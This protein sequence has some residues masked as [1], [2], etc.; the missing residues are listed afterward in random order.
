MRTNPSQATPRARRYGCAALARL[1]LN[2]QNR[3]MVAAAGGVKV[4]IVAM[5][6]HVASAAVQEYGW[7][8]LAC[9]HACSHTRAHAHARTPRYGCLAL[10]RLAF[11]EDNRVEV[12]ECARREPCDR[13]ACVE[14]LLAIAIGPLSI[15][16]SA[17]AGSA[18]ST[19]C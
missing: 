16:V 4:V 10:A 5:Q 8:A 9:K 2:P 13:C 18:G 3:V 1:A 15:A 17:A 11:N 14:S 6:V 19:P 12:A 7:L